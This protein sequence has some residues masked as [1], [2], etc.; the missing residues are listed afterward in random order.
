MT[1]TLSL[2]RKPLVEGDKTCADVTRDVCDPLDRTPTR[3][4]WLGFG[5]SSTALL[6]G[7]IMV[8]DQVWTGIG[9][10]G[11]NK[12]IGWSFDI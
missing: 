2:L 9:T 10:W 5:L 6:T 7:L 8:I 12:T 4:W 1:S 11:L 3:L